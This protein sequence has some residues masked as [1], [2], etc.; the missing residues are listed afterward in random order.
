MKIYLD[1]VRTPKDK[2]WMVVRN[3]YELVNLVQKVGI[4]NI[5]TISLDRMPLLYALVFISLIVYFFHP[6]QPLYAD[7]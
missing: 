5:S 6:A 7:V 2:D 4:K 3:Y 1:D